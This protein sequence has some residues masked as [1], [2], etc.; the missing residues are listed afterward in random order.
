MIAIRTFALINTAALLGAPVTSSPSYDVDLAHRST[1]PT[2]AGALSIMSYNIKGLPWP[3]AGGREEAISAMGQRLAAMRLS[4]AQPHVVLLQEAFGDGAHTLG[5]AGGYRYV[6]TGPQFSRADEPQPLGQAFAEGAQWVK[7]EASGSLINS[8][9]AILS[10][11]PVIRI[12]R[13]AFPEGACAGYDCLAAKGVLVAW[14]DVPGT[15]GPIAVI[16]THLN[17]RRAT[18]VAS[19][20]A[21][22]AYAWQ[23]AAV[24]QF[25]ARVL[26]SGT[27]VIFGGDFNTGQAPARIAA[28][29]QPLIEGT[30]SDGLRTVLTN[31]GVIS[32]SRSEAQ[33]I[34]GR[35]KDKIL[36]RDG[37][38]V[39]LRPERAWV[40]FPITSPAPL[41]DHAGFV[42]DFSFQRRDTRECLGACNSIGA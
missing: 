30:Q 35:N 24:R 2:P 39:S 13:Y 36:F 28:L 12:E 7:G 25:L 38:R 29:S 9:L 23:V 31:G 16:D 8:G 20:R 33:R 34:V 11:Y 1:W 15:G 27:P 19:E 4:N 37:L 40:P 6:V 22:R 42:L 21:D 10:D 14:I 41:S 5:E 17:S 32:G 3:I 18:R 26:P